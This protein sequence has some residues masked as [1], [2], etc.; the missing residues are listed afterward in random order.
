MIKI[1]SNT[2]WI[3]KQIKGS[4][5]YLFILG[6][7]VLISVFAN[8]SIA[9][10]LKMFIDVAMNTTTFTIFQVTLLSGCVLIIGGV[11]YVASSLIRAKVECNL[12]IKLRKS[13]MQALING[14]F[15]QSQKYHSA[16][17]LTKLTNDVSSV[18]AFYPVIIN[19]IIGGISI[20][21]F[22][23]I[24]LFLLNIKI[25][26]AIV[27]GIPIIIAVV[28]LFNFPIA[29]ADKKRKQNEEKNRIL[30]QEH[31]NRIEIIKLYNIQEKCVSM[32]ENLYR[33]TYRSKLIFSIW[34]GVA[35]FLNGL[36]SNAMLLISLGVGAYFVIIGETTVGTL[37]AILQLLNYIITPLSRVSNAFSQIAQAKTSAER[38]RDLLKID[39]DQCIVDYYDEFDSLHLRNVSFAY[40]DKKVLNDVNISF[41][42]NVCYC[43]K[44]ENGSGKTTLIKLISELYQPDEGQVYLELKNGNKSVRSIRNHIS[45]VPA[46]ESL[47]NSSIKDNVTMFST[48]I[49]ENKLN[50]V[51]RQA[52]LED[53]IS[54]L[55]DGVETILAENGKSL[56]SGQAQRIVLARAMYHDS[57][58]IIFDEPTSNLDS[59]SID[60]FFEIINKI[61]YNR[62]IIIVSHSK[63]VIEFCD[64]C[65]SIHENKCIPIP[66]VVYA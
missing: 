36:I 64:E 8:I 47:F 61:K 3:F 9:F 16:D 12:E 43:I 24:S 13:I 6:V 32:I 10:I 42:K 31:I 21:I 45:I 53:Y 66:E 60:K 63:R 37:V 34:E 29:K 28:S 15:Y 35:S 5:L 41:Q 44:G 26:L 65:Y 46:N 62:I 59:E 23:I 51:L 39:L 38:I 20:S 54:T 11:M 50:E 40:G 1:E 7:V 58:I 4:R 55:K 2:K 33:K 14:S 56:S 48:D 17:V 22:A 30:M 52:K 18:S 25:A 49:D 57:E 19:E 27:I